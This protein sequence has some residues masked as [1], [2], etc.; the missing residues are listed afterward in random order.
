M[1][2]RLPLLASGITLFASFVSACSDDVSLSG[3]DGIPMEP[4]PAA[5]NRP[6]PLPP[7][8]APNEDA[9]TPKRPVDGALLVSG[10]VKVVGVTDDGWLAYF[11]TAP[12]ATF[13]SFE[14]FDTK[15]KKRVSLGPA[16]SANDTAMVRGNAVALWT[17]LKAPYGWGGLSVWTEASGVT[18][19][20]SAKSLPGLFATNADGT[21][22]A[23]TFGLPPAG[24]T[25]LATSAPA[26]IA[27]PQIVATNVGIGDKT[28]SCIPQ[29]GFH[30]TRLFTSSC[31]GAATSGTV[32]MIDASGGVTTVR[33]AARPTWSADS[34]GT[35]IL[36]T[37]ASGEAELH[38]M[39]NNEVVPVA[40][41]VASA[42]LTP[43]GATVLHTTAG[44]ALY[45]APVADPTQA[46]AL[47]ANGA[48]EILG[49]SPD[50][51]HAVMASLP[52]DPSSTSTHRTDLHL[53]ALDTPSAPAPTIPLLTTATGMA[54][55][56]TR[57]GSHVLYITDLTGIGLED[58]QLRARPVTGGPEVVLGKEVRGIVQPSG[59]TRSSSA[60]AQR[61]IGST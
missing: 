52:P 57:S 40:A 30:G 58:M 60:N 32:R 5:T 46:K 39:P 14:V 33:S 48:R 15:T 19:A 11:V 13:A 26:A 38:T 17:N 8:P 9:G 20:K 41:N 59:S 55:G 56:F 50:G 45:R 61:A 36:V 16:G 42:V 1:K 25:Q 18:S 22:L 31:E 34:N 27:A 51:A 23:Y 44:G 28:T 21:R 54:Y 35:R 47:L 12:G 53:V 2:L 7:E 3:V 6:E 37:S 10:K 43:D 4:P 24:I 29:I 49:V